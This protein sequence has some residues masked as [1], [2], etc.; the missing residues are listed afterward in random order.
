MEED[1]EQARIVSIRVGS[2]PAPDRETKKNTATGLKSENTQSETETL[3][4]STNRSG[5]TFFEDDEPNG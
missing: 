5:N 1:E 4:P 3:E 2:I